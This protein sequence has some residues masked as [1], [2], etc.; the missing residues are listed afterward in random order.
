[1]P[2]K[3]VHD[4]FEV[5]VERCLEKDN[6]LLFDEPGLWNEEN[7]NIAVNCMLGDLPNRQKRL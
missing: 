6:S 2:Y 4:L 3:T 7:L 5:W 1:M